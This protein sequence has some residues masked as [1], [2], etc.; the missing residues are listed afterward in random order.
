[1]GGSGYFV[2]HWDYG[3]VVLSPVFA[4]LQTCHRLTWRL[5]PRALCLRLLRRLSLL[6]SAPQGKEGFE[7]KSSRAKCGK[8]NELALAFADTLQSIEVHSQPAP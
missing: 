1:M 8:L 3:R 2:N 4:G 6:T 5:R 7:S